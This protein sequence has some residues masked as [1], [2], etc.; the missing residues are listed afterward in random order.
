MTLLYHGTN[1]RWLTN[2]LRRG[3]EP[4]GARPARDNWKHVAHK[5]NPRAVYLTDS[6]APYFAFNAARGEDAMCAV[7]EVDTNSLEPHHLFPDED[8]LE[9]LGRGWDGVPGTM[10]QRTLVYR[11]RQFQPE[12]Y[13]LVKK[14]TELPFDWADSLRWLGTCCHR[15]TIPVS[16]IIR[17]V[18]WPHRQN[19]WMAFVW[20]PSITLMNQRICGNR[21]RALTARLFGDPLPEGLAGFDRELVERFDPEK[22]ED[23]KRITMPQRK[24]A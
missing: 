12:E 16:A 15:G 11:S 22:I 10:S 18:T 14:D 21:Y 2:I 7:M 19:A 1:G 24:A 8:C 23:L 20:D 3:I 6:Y 9:Q 4:R 17:A 5:S 13:G